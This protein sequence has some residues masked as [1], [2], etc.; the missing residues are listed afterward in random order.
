MTK[1]EQQVLVQ[2]CEALRA[3]IQCQEQANR[4]W[5]SLYSVLKHRFPTIDWDKEVADHQ[6]NVPPATALSQ[7]LWLVSEKLQA[8][9]E[10]LRRSQDG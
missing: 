3:I 10:S 4:S 2:A 5:H 8:V 1:E 6:T 7:Q 9:I